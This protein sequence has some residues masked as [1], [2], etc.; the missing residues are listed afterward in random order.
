VHNGYTT[1]AP[2]SGWHHLVG[3]WDGATR[4][5]Y[6]DGVLFGSNTSAGSD[7]SGDTQTLGIGG[8]PTYNN[9]GWS[10]GVYDARI[11]NRALTAAEISAIYRGLQ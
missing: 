6:L 7:S 9:Y 10:G 5:I 11:Y 3:T 2:K 4:R 1:G 8:K